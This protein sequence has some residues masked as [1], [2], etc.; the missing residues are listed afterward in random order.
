MTRTS[1]QRAHVSRKTVQKS[2]SGALKGGLG[3]LRLRTATCWRRASTSSAVS[4]RLRKKTRAAARNASTNDTTISR[5][6]TP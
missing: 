6:N 4:A 5:F 3:R 1:S 2:R